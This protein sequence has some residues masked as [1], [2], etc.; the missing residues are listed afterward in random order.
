[1]GLFETSNSYEDAFGSL[2]AIFGLSISE[3]K[4]VELM[5]KALK[6]GS[7]LTEKELADG[8]GVEEAPPDAI[9]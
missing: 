8:A 2:P 3:E 4:L 9:L 7:P 5:N 6:R 1:M